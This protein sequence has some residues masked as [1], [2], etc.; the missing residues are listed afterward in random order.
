MQKYLIYLP[1]P[2]KKKAI[3]KLFIKYSTD[4]ESD[5]YEMEKN[6][7]KFEFEVDDNFRWIYDNRSSDVI[8]IF[9]VLLHYFGKKGELIKIIR[10]TPEIIK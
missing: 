8:G 9:E 5:V 3:S 4:K 10:P 6:I 1:P 2:V 7:H